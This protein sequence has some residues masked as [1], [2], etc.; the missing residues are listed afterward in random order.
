MRQS[1]AHHIHG[2][3]ETLLTPKRLPGWDRTA[4]AAPMLERFAELGGAVPVC[5]SVCLS[6]RQYGYAWS[7]RGQLGLRLCPHGHVVSFNHIDP[8]DNALRFLC[9]LTGL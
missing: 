1:S 8:R 7:T 6:V 3:E 5:L 2:G 9:L 4:L